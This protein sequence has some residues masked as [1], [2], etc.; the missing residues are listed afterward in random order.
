[1]R[2]SWPQRPQFAGSTLVSVHLP[3]QI[4]SG[5]RQPPLLLPAEVVLDADDED[6]VELPLEEPPAPLLLDELAVLP[7]EP[8]RPPEALVLELLV[9]AAREP[10]VLAPAVP[11]LE[12]SSLRP[13]QCAAAMGAR[14]SQRVLRRCMVHPRR[15]S[16]LRGTAPERATIS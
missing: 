3:A 14:R 11:A 10:P 13:P 16:I 15:N 5:L 7:A 9:P 12:A 8:P 6:L 2:Q 4:S 1:P